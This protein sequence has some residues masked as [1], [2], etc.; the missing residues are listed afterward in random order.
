MFYLM[1]M[2]IEDRNSFYSFVKIE[3]I[4]NLMKKSTK[5]LE[6]NCGGVLKH[7]NVRDM[8]KNSFFQKRYD[9]MLFRLCRF[10]NPSFVFEVGT[11][12]GFSTMYFASVKKETPVYTMCRAKVW[13]E[14]A[15]QNFSRIGLSNINI[16]K[17]NLREQLN[18]CC[19]K[20]GRDDGL[21]F[22]NREATI[23]D[24]RDVMNKIGR[25][26]GLESSDVVIVSDIH[27]S[28][29][30]EMLWSEIRNAEGVRVDFDLFFYGVL[31]FNKEL[32][33]ESYNIFYFPSLFE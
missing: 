22:L 26:R 32:Q 10:F 11:S 33:K 20:E 13:E 17:G 5:G 31:L 1:T 9:Q 12:L 2:I 30:K 4:R 8:I 15:K 29:E 6:Q 24:I 3:A 18:Q 21:F 19:D 25:G 16:L 14:M 27:R 28:K 7:Y 23:E